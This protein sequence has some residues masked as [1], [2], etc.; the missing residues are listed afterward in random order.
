MSDIPWH[1]SPPLTLEHPRQ[2]VT[3]EILTALQQPLVLLLAAA[4]YGKT[5]A[6]RAVWQSTNG[7]KAWW[8]VRASDQNPEQGLQQLVGAARYGWGMAENEDLSLGALLADLARAQGGLLVIDDACSW[9]TP[10]LWGAI[11]QLV[12]AMPAPCHLLLLCRYYPPLPVTLWRSQGR[13]ALLHHELLELTAEEWQTA[14]FRGGEAACTAARGWWGAEV[15]AMTSTQNAN[16]SSWNPALAAWIH[17]AWFAPLPKEQQTLLGMASLLPELTLDNLCA[18]SGQSAP[19]VY[20]TWADIEAIS[21]PIVVHD[22]RMAIAPRYRLY[23]SQ[24]WRRCDTEAWARTINAGI[25]RLLEQGDYGVACTLAYES[26]L[27]EQQERV[28]E[29]AGWTLLY[30]AQRPIL[31]PLL[32][33]SF[34]KPSANTSLLQMAWQIEVLRLPHRVDANLVQ[35]SST[36]EGPLRGRALALLASIGWQYDDFDRAETN[37]RAALEFFENDLHPAYTL[38]QTLL[39]SALLIKG[40]LSEAE[41]ILRRAQAYATRDGLPYLQLDVLQR[42]ALLATENGDTGVALTLAQETHV[43]ADRYQLSAAGIVDSSARLIAWLHLQKLEF[44]AAE[45]ALNYGPYAAEPLAQRQ[46]FAH[47]WFSSVL[48]L[49]ADAVTSAQTQIDWINHSLSQQFWPHKWQNEASIVQLW[50]AARTM[51][52]ARLLQLEQ[53]LAQYKWPASLHTDRRRVMLAAARLL[54]DIDDDIDTLKNLQQ[55]LRQQGAN[56]LA[57]QLELIMLLQQDPVDRQG[58]LQHLRSSAANNQGFDYL[59]LGNKT[60]GPLEKLLTAPEL[61]HDSLTLSFLRN[62]VQRL[63]S[64]PSLNNDTESAP[65]SAPPAG[66]TSKEWQI[67]QLIGQQHT[68]DQIAAKLFVS[69][70]TVK[71]HIN[72]IYSKLDIKTRAE[73]VHRAR[74]L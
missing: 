30:Q 4:G 40:K 5:V 14:G 44:S 8:T 28:L 55:Q 70:A 10:A 18:L 67:L 27:P 26:G 22:D 1:P 12:A 38:A 69:L 19:Q 73:A 41:P 52:R 21:G 60:I 72:H 53:Q 63:L 33:Q 45:A 34:A 3:T 23:V 25:T 42:R 47:R 15:A 20:S 11:G 37:A 13:L 7:N 57:H 39:G 43:L 68:N 50:L 64:P 2:R 74:S 35:L 17:E 6:A 65:E 16:Q 56:T 31:E 59:W 36:L 9:P 46:N 49:A 71:T 58:L 66:L 24:A 62:I 61:I 51:D 32:K 48:N 29:V 54:A